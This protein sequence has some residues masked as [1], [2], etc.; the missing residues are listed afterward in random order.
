MK[1]TVLLVFLAV[2]IS[3]SLVAQTGNRNQ[4]GDAGW[5]HG[6]P[7]AERM[8]E[9]LSQELDLS[10]E[11][12]GQLLTVL[13][14]AEAERE[15]LHQQALEQMKPEIC[16][17]HLD[18]QDQVRQILSDDQYAELEALKTER[19]ERRAQGKGKRP[20]IGVSPDC[21]EFEG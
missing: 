4:Q 16:A 21:S 12:A 8:V 15:A 18:T 6:P 7:S 3:G 9:R 13:K 14:E 10:A 20:G 17:L 2:L 19:A 5:R 1:R 11:Q